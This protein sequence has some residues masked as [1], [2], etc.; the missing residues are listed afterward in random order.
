MHN[1]GTLKR[2]VKPGDTIYIGTEIAITV[3]DI[4]KSGKMGLIIRADKSYKILTNKHLLSEPEFRSALA[5]NH[6]L[7]EDLDKGK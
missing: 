2:D 6:L 1:H 5:S 7:P 3:K 4:N